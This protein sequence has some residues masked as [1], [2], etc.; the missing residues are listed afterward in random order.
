MSGADRPDPGPIPEHGIVV[1]PEGEGFYARA[2]PRPR[3]G[4]APFAA[5]V[6]GLS[7]I[8]FV[9]SRIAGEAPALRFQVVTGTVLFGLLIAGV[10]FGYGFV[11]VEVSADDETVYWA[12]ERFPIALVGSCRAEERRLVL[13]GR[14]GRELGSIAHLR[15]EVALWLG[16][17][18]EASLPSD[19]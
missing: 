14:D 1:R 10:L 3:L 17:A 11:P 6:I 2:W 15:P 13:R 12:G 9:A 16:R 8:G 5:V 18:V 4:L 7:A 19:R